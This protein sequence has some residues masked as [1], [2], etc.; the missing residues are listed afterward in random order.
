MFVAVATTRMGLPRLGQA[1]GL[2]R[3]RWA[4]PPEL[5]DVGCEA[6][7]PRFATP[8]F[9]GGISQWQWPL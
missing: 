3:S 1:G 9:H 6:R 4:I 2:S 5:D 7:H 8:R